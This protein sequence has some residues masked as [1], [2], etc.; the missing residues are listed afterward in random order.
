LPV[1][2]H[3]QRSL[4]YDLRMQI[5][6]QSLSESA[7]HAIVQE[8]V[9]RDGTD[10]SPIDARIRAI[11]KQLRNG[12]LVIHFDDETETCNIILALGKQSM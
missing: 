1:F 4:L 5:P 7:L 2:L 10:N 8:F 12:R 3:L 9:T 11:L 6:Y